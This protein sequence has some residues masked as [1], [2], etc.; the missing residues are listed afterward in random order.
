MTAG[1]QD[2][3]TRWQKNML[4]HPGAGLITSAL[5]GLSHAHPLA[6]MLKTLL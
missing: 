5:L 6:A 2:Q 1:P 3:P 4:E